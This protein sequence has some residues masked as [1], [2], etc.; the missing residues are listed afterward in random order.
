MQGSCWK[1]R[2]AKLMGKKTTGG[3]RFGQLKKKNGSKR[4]PVGQNLAGEQPAIKLGLG[5]GSTRD[6]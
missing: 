1:R 2:G 6:V 5:L 3:A 4:A